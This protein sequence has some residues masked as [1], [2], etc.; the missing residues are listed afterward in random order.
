MPQEAMFCGEHIN[1]TEN[2][3]VLHTAMRNTTEDAVMYQ[4]ENIMDSIPSS[5]KMKDFVH[6]IHSGQWK[7]FTGKAITDV[8]NIGIGGSDLGPLMVTEALA[9]YASHQGTFCVKCGW[10]AYR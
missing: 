2:R 9:P 7:G 3:A 4:G 8:V 6:E 5:T 10:Y 1:Q